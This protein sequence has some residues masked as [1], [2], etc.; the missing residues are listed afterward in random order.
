MNPKLNITQI[1]ATGAAEKK[2]I[3]SILLVTSRRSPERS[4]VPNAEK[5]KTLSPSLFLTVLVKTVNPTKINKHS[6]LRID[7]TLV[8]HQI[9]RN[10]ITGNVSPLHAASIFL[11]L[12]FLLRACRLP[13][14][15]FGCQLGREDIN[16]PKHHLDPNLISLPLNYFIS[17]IL[18][19]PF[20]L[21]SQHQLILPDQICSCLTADHSV[22]G[23]S[24]R[25]V[26]TLLQVG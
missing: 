25:F 22:P 18:S 11:S 3:G 20:P 19:L 4:I 14:F 6:P 5:R 16:K 8:L 23:Y 17:L 12:S 15:R 10:E 21:T 2:S 9:R 13:S 7:D 24:L 1:R 26:L